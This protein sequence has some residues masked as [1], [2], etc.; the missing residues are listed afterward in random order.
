M[1][2]GEK[3]RLFMKEKGVSSYRLAKDIGVHPSTVKNWLDGKSSPK[4]GMVV[5]M[6]YVLGVPPVYLIGDTYTDYIE[7]VR[8]GKDATPEQRKMI[9]EYEANAR[10]EDMMAR[11]DY[12]DFERKKK[13]HEYV[14]DLSKMQQ[15]EA[16]TMPNETNNDT[17]TP[18]PNQDDSV[19][20]GLAAYGGDSD[21][22]TIS[23]EQAQKI[24]K[25]LKEM[26]DNSDS[27][28]EE[29]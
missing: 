9:E 20:I 24:S 23:K 5:D 10:R 22:S 3:V 19:R 8:A 29:E 26:Q 14:V 25:R 2:F 17:S 16:T 11:Y 7:A 28:E 1:T 13:A 27:T 12:L 4:I 18:S 6:A 21:V 15:Y